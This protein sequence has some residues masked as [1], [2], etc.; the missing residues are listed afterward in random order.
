MNKLLL[1]VIVFTS[2]A[3]SAQDY[4]TGKMLDRNTN[5]REV[6]FDR[7]QNDITSGVYQT[8]YKIKSRDKKPLYT[9]L[10]THDK[11]RHSLMFTIKPENDAVSGRTI[12]Y[13]PIHCGLVF[14]DKN[15]LDTIFNLSNNYAHLVSFTDTQR[16][17]PVLHKLRTY[18]NVQLQLDPLSKLRIRKHTEVVNQLLTGNNESAFNRSLYQLRDSLYAQ[19]LRLHNQAEAIHDRIE[20]DINRLLADKQVAIGERR[21]EGEKRGGSPNGTGLLVQNGNIYSGTFKDGKFVSGVVMIK[22]D[23]YEYYGE[24]S[25]NNYNGTGFIKYDNEGY[26]LGNFI[27]GQLSAGVVLQKEIPGEVYFG[28]YIQ[29]RNGYGEFQSKQGK[30]VGKFSNG[31]LVKGYCK[32]TDPFGYYSYGQVDGGTKTTIDA[33]AAEAFFGLSLSAAAK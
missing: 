19:S 22:K 3:A 18:D 23:N 20:N 13:D 25:D 28:S 10:V 12:Y 14:N 16:T 21:Y 24:Y 15:A 5:E 27:N 32:E 17:F 1:L 26:M 6:L 31:R 33:T 11:N 7:T 9:L 2:L 4:L 29:G 30:Y 8:V